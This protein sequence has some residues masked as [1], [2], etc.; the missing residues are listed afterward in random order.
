MG[1]SV[2]VGII[3]DGRKSINHAVA[4]DKSGGLGLRA[5]ESGHTDVCSLYFQFSRRLD[6]LIGCQGD[7]CMC[8][9]TVDEHKTLG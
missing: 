5:C 8:E 4:S 2:D 6:T 9:I 7:G 1:K 3:C